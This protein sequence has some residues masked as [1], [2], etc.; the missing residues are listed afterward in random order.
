MG[1]HQIIVTL[2]DMTGSTSYA[3]SLSI[4]DPCLQSSAISP[5]TIPPIGAL[6]NKSPV[7]YTF[8]ATTACG[9]ATFSLLSTHSWLSISSAANSFTV[10]VSPKTNSDAGSFTVQ[11]KT[12]LTNYSTVAVPDTSFTVTIT[13]NTPPKFVEASLPQQQVNKP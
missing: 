11:M 13:P 4:T 10:A 6:V 2:A 12:T 8:S 7:T 1:T 3:L 9:P 5:I